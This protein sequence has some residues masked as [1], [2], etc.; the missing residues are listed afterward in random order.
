TGQN[1][2]GR[3]VVVLL[4][5]FRPDQDPKKDQPIDT[6][7]QK[8][9]FKGTQVPRAQVEFPILPSKYG[10]IPTEADKPDKPGEKPAKPAKPEEKPTKPEFKVG[11]WKF[12]AR[13]ARDPAETF[14]DKFHVKE[15]VVVKVVKRARRV[16]LM[17]SAPMRDYQFVRTLMVRESDKKRLELSIFLQPLPGQAARPGIVQDVPPDRMLKQFPDRLDDKKATEEAQYNLANYDV[18]VAFDPDWTQLTKEQCELVE[19]WVSQ[20][21]GGLVV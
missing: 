2:V 20:Q 9:P 10:E 14:G 19:R 16:P 17:A 1:L 8:V 13:V 12:V 6:I 15:P 4:D 21:G 11:D 3:D 5:V 18:I 7:E